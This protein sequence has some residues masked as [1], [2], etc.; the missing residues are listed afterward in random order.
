MHPV[1]M[2]VLPFV[3]QGYCC[4]QLLMLLMLQ[5]RGE[6]NPALVRSLQGLCHG[7]GHSEGDC[8]LLPGGAC[9]LALLCGKGADEEVPHQMLNPLLNEYATWFYERTAQYGGYTCPQVAAGL[10]ARKGEDG[11]PDPVACGELLADCWVKIGELV[12]SYGL[13]ITATVAE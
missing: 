8:G 11:V 12:E 4:S 2:D 6:E 5:A 10:G 1:L 7:I 9:V 13:D 3:R